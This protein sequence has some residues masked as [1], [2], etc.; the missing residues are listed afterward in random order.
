LIFRIT[1]SP[2]GKFGGTGAIEGFEPGKEVSSNEKREM[3]IFLITTSSNEQHGYKVPRNGDGAGY[4][5]KQM[6]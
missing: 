6:I 4:F 1:P 2:P 3:P 5:F